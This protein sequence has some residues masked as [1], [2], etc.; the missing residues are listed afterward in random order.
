MDHTP[1]PLPL[2]SMGDGEWADIAEVR[3][4]AAWVTRLAELG[5][6][7]GRRLLV[8]RSGSPCLLQLGGSRISLRTEAASQ[9]LVRRIAFV[10]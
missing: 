3:G 5:I 8:L 6:G 2:Q 9:I 7:A 1:P 10:G 4:D